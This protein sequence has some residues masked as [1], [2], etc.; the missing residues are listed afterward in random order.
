MIFPVRV[1]SASTRLK[2]ET[3]ITPFNT[4]GVNSNSSMPSRWYTHFAWSRDGSVM[5]TVSEDGFVRL[6][7]RDGKMT[8]EA[9]LSAE[10]G[11]NTT[12][13]AVV[14]N[15]DGSE[16]LY[17]GVTDVG[18]VGFIYVKTGKHRLKFTKHD[19]S[20]FD[21]ALSADGKTA[22]SV[23]GNDHDVLVWNPADGEVIHTLKGA[24]RSVWLFVA[25]VQLKNTH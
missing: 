5:A 20:V 18:V 14:F 15:A 11:Q 25:A 6:W 21:V 13:A 1:S 23:G 7:D 3:Y 9:N 19:N 17:G 8:K 24:G 16:V 12:L 4:I 2:P 22:A 10:N